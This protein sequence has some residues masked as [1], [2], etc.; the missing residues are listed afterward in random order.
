MQKSARLLGLLGFW[1]IAV[2]SLVIRSNWFGYP[3]KLVHTA[4]HAQ[5]MIGRISSQ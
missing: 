4:V 2:V 3:L 1:N 5:T